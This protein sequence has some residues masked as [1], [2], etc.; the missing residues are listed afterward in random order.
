MLTGYSISNVVLDAPSVERNAN[1]LTETN[2]FTAL[3]LSVGYMF[4]N[5]KIQVG[6]FMGND[7][8]SRVNQ[9]NFGW[10]YQGKPWF[11]IGLGYSIFSTEKPKT[12]SSKEKQD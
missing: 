2:N 3:S 1:L 7:N 9:E 11:S 8:L 4:E 10:Q 6:V 5:E 12:D